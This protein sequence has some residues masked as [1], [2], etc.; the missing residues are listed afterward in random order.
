MSNQNKPKGERYFTC[1]VFSLTMP[2]SECE[3]RR[4]MQ[5]RKLSEP[6]SIA[7]EVST[8]FMTRQCVS[9][10]VYKEVTSE[11]NTIS[12]EEM[13]AKYELNPSQTSSSARFPKPYNGS[14]NTPHIDY[15]RNSR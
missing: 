15:G 12:H 11:E 5:S 7:E 8:R 2:V 1:P 13:M 4:G 9:C 3:K 6:T 10:E 14:L